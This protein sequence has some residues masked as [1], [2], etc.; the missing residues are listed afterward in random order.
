MILKVSRLARHGSHGGF[1]FAIAS[2]W[3]PMSEPTLCA[4]LQGPSCYIHAHANS[5]PNEHP[6]GGGGGIRNTSEFLAL[7][8]I[9]DCL[10]HLL[11]GRT[12]FVVAVVAGKALVALALCHH[13]FTPTKPKHIGFIGLSVSCSRSQA[14]DRGD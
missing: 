13:M 2:K 6:H 8:F 4:F 12:E 9:L 11:E 3:G 14:K 1:C 5:P 7:L 10:A